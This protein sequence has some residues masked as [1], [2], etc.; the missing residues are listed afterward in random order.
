MALLMVLNAVLIALPLLLLSLPDG[1]THQMSESLRSKVAPTFLAAVKLK[2]QLEPE[3][4]PVQLVKAVPV[5]CTVGEAVEAEPVAVRLTDVPDAKFALHVPELE[6][7][8]E[9]P[10]GVELTVPDPVTVV[11]RV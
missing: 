4:S 2:V 5:P 1:D 11:V 10:G 9:I 8:V 6:L 3:Q 7:H